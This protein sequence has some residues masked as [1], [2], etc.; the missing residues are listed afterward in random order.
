VLINLAYDLATQCE[1]RRA[2]L[3]RHTIVGCQSFKSINDSHSVPPSRP[4]S[5][6]STDHQSQQ[7]QLPLQPQQVEVIPQPTATAA[8]SN[9]TT[10]DNVWAKNSLDENEWK[11]KLQSDRLSLT[12]EEIVHI[13]SVITKAELESLPMGIQIKEDVEKRKLCF[14]CLRTKFGIL[15]PRGVSCKL[16]Q[17]TVCAKCY[18]K[19]RIPTEHFSNIPVQLLSPSRQNS[20][21]ISNVPSPSHHAN[22]AGAMDESFPR[23]LMER[24]LRTDVDRKTRNT[25]GSAPSSPKNQRSTSSTPGSSQPN[26]LSLINNGVVASSI[27]YNTSN[28]ATMSAKDNQMS[29]RNSIMSRSMEGPRSLPPQ[30]PRSLPHSNCSTLDRR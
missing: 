22:M 20:P 5:R 25:V 21:S 3:R 29:L 19:M 8:S 26:S 24:L 2:S 11:E 30:S 23:S 1:S 27:N 7:Q 28:Y 18:T 15:G 10:M 9:L 4:S 13:R 6:Q 14:L 12:L 17:R 16:C